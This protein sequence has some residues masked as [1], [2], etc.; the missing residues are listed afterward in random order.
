LEIEVSKQLYL[1]GSSMKNQSGAAL[2]LLALLVACQNPANNDSNTN[3]NNPPKN[4][5]RVVFDNTQGI[6]A[7]AVYDDHQRRE[8]YR[9]AEIPAGSSSEEIEW[10][11]SKSHPFYFTYLIALAGIGDVVVPYIPAVGK[12][13]VAVRIDENK[14]TLVSVPA[15][16]EALSSPDELLSG[17]SYVII[18]NLSSFSFQLLKGSASLKPDNSPD[19]AV[20]NNGEKALY[21]ITPGT[22]SIY[23]LRSGVDSFGLEPFGS[24]EA[25]H[26]YRLY[27]DGD[28]IGM[29]AETE[30]KPENILPPESGGT[31]PDAPGL[32]TAA[33]GDGLVTVGWLGVKDA[34]AYEVY[35]SSSGTPSAMPSKTV[36]GHTTVTVITG[37]NNRSAYTIWIKAANGYGASGYSPPVRCTPWPDTARPQV[38]GSVEVIPGNGRLSVAWEA[39][40]GASSYNVYINESTT[41]PAL[42]NRTTTETNTVIEGLKNSVIYYVWV[43]A[44]NNNGSSDYSLIEAGQPQQP[45]TPP[46][47]PGVSELIPGSGELIVRWRPVKMAESYEVWAGTSGNFADASKHGEDISGGTTQTIITGLVNETTYYVWVKAK[48]SAGTSGFGPRASAKPSVFAAAPVAPST[49]PLVSSGDGRLTATWTAVEGASGY[50]IWKNNQNN[51]ATAEK[52]GGDITATSVDITGLANGTTCYVWVK[53][54]NSNGVSSFSPP[55]S[56][57]PLGTPDAPEIITGDSRLTATW[58]AVAGASAYEL[59]IAETDDSDAAEWIGGD[60]SGDLTKTI[61]GLVNETTYYVWVKAKNSSGVSAF[62]SPA[63]G[64]P[65]VVE[66]FSITVGFNYNEITI[67]GSDGINGISKSGAAG[68]PQTLFLSAADYDSIV[69][70]VDGNTA[71]GIAD[72]GT[73]TSLAASDYP[74]QTHS[75]T[76]TGKRNGVL[77]SRTMPF[78]VYD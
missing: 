64:T 51:H 40:A 13:Q 31:A 6:C 37:L 58:T 48:N 56:G 74:V 14:Q 45:A 77:Y 25:G 17:D 41:P 34:E 16:E 4:R 12:D 66:N 21:K 60:I 71:E 28:N 7:V 33:A 20:V 22:A 57:T 35:L 54:K 38:P 18:Q 67:S 29:F 61:N 50:E 73:G 72:G 55:A 70:Y 3:N 26:I 30:I 27:F 68:R 65:A 11:P 42:P 23:S 69:W 53:A 32:P 8:T 9:I 19:S 15:L 46:A 2:F 59:W 44:R 24:F 52:Y 75:I 39:A 36:P 47:A 62:S 1:K 43:E 49:A 76:F 63:N 78:T 5:T 10:T